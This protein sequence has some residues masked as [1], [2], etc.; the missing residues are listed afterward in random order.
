MLLGEANDTW[1]TPWHGV[2]VKDGDRFR[3]MR[4]HEAEE[5]GAR[6]VEREGRPSY[7]QLA[8]KRSV[9]VF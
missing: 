2:A 7:F 1:L 4:R 5:L 9:K 8:S 6:V 3:M